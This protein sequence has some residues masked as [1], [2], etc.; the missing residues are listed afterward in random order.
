[1]NI[2]LN[3]IIYILKNGKIYFIVFMD[4]EDAISLK[5]FIKQYKDQNKLIEQDIITNIISQICISLIELHKDKKIHRNLIPE[6]IFIYKD[7]KI[8][9]GE[10]KSQN[11]I[12][13]DEQYIDYMAPE[14]EK[15][16]NYDNYDNRVDTYS[17]GC[18]I[19]ELFTLNVYKKENDEK[20]CKINTEIYD[21]RWQELLDLLLEKDYNKRPYIEEVYYKYI[22]KNEISLNLKIDKDDINKQIYYLDNTPMHNHLKEIDTSNKVLNIYDDTNTII[23]NDKKIKKFFIPK[24]EG[25][26]TIKILL[27]NSIKDC[28]YM[29]CDCSNITNI[30]LSSFDTEQ[31]NDMSYMFKGCSNL[32]SINLSSFKTNN[33]ENMDH[34]F[35]YCKNLV[36]LDLSSFD[37]KNV[38]NMSCLFYNCVNLEKINILKTC[39]TK[40][41]NTMDYMFGNCT[42]LKEI[43]LSSFDLS[44]A[45]DLSYMFCDCIN[46]KKLVLPVLPLE[47]DMFGIFS[48]CDNLKVPENVQ[49]II[50]K[51]NPYFQP[52]NFE[53]SKI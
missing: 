10:A 6:N 21:K 9:I 5:H 23:D 11:T 25:I 40:N 31:V 15:T 29:F 8:K 36:E 30:D 22:K 53:E 47:S 46:L 19:Y 50:K 49:K 48:H 16:G 37:T 35:C 24:K 42:N 14:I 44:N 3:N 26:Y 17:L 27:Y 12:I 4:N 33:V 32:E 13:G 28:S 18:I 52:N 41:V 2:S 43:D 7:N 51:D 34:M 39:D 20:V 38:T 45:R 1:M